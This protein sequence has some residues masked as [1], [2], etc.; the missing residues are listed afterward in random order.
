[1]E[2]NN[3][4]KYESPELQTVLFDETDVVTLSG[5]TDPVFKDGYDDKDFW[6]GIMLRNSAEIKYCVRHCSRVR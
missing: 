3:K 1:M 6:E 5:D 2:Q 4:N